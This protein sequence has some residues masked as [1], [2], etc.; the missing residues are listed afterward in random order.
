MEKMRLKIITVI[1]L[2]LLLC[3]SGAYAATVGEI[4]SPD[5]A[6]YKEWGNGNRYGIAVELSTIRQQGD[7]ITCQSIFFDRYTRIIMDIFDDEIIELSDGKIEV[8]MS[9]R[10]N[11]IVDTNSRPGSEWVR[12]YKIMKAKLADDN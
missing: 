7:V 11:V 1:S 8:V 3:C 6:S 4:F 5:D 12:L 2:V 9:N 10:P